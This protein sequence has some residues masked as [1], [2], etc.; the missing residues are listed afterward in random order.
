MKIPKSEKKLIE[1]SFEGECLQELQRFAHSSK[2]GDE[3]QVRVDLQRTYGLT[4]G[5]WHYEQPSKR[6]S[7]IKTSGLIEPNPDEV[8][9]YR[10]KSLDKKF[11][12]FILLNFHQ[13]GMFYAARQF[14]TFHL[15]SLG[16]MPNS[17]DGH[18][19][20]FICDFGNS[21]ELV[22]TE[23]FNVTALDFISNTELLYKVI[24]KD[25]EFS[26]IN[27]NQVDKDKILY[28]QENL[29]KLLGDKVSPNY[30]QANLRLEKKFKDENEKTQLV[31]NSDENANLIEFTVKH[32]LKLDPI[33]PMGIKIKEL[34]KEDISF[35]VQAEL[36]EFS[37]ETSKAEFSKLLSPNL[38]CVSSGFFARPKF[39]SKLKDLMLNTY[40]EFILLLLNIIF[41]LIES[42]IPAKTSFLSPQPHQSN[43][44]QNNFAYR[45]R[46]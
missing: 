10:I 34:S 11:Q 17:K 6:G 3:R 20:H 27:L 31:F 29:M 16:F 1:L 15:N 38:P 30:Q 9:F 41:K 37:S 19:H 25:E 24:A 21:D 12:D 5:K 2:S 42:P 46:A 28:F 39:G 35:K 7:V 40:R 22:I 13:G 36:Y 32:T 43:E 8:F 26:C 33:S 18:R 45:M 44:S 4:I 14:L 23:K